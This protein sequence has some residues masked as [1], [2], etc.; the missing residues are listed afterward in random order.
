VWVTIRNLILF[1]WIPDASDS[2]NPRRA[3]LH[4][5]SMLR[6]LAAAAALETFSLFFE[7]NLEQITFKR[8]AI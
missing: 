8:L 5:P 1:T 2:G 3:A 6:I 7:F 4:P